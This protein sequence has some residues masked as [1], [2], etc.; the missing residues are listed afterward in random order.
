MRPVQ[1]E[2][3]IRPQPGS[4]IDPRDA[5]GRTGTTTRARREFAAGNNLLL[6]DP[7]RMGK[8]VWLELFCTDPGVEVVAVKIDYEGVRSREEF[9]LRTI[10]G[11]S[12]HRSMP[13]KALEKFRALFENLDVSAS[14]GPITV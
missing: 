14:V 13:A 7:R 4:Q 3:P 12:G 9:L 10:E 6:N 2:S 5:V 11:L 8:T 1:N